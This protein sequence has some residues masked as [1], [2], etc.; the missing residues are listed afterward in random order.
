MMHNKSFF[1]RHIYSR[2]LKTILEPPSVGDKKNFQTWLFKTQCT[3]NIL[4]TFYYHKR[5]MLMILYTEFITY[6]LSQTC[7]GTE[8]DSVFC[9]LGKTEKKPQTTCYFNVASQ[10]PFWYN[11]KIC[12]IDIKRKA[13]QMLDI[14][15]AF[16]LVFTR[17]LFKQKNEG[18]LGL[19][20]MKTLCCSFYLNY[21]SIFL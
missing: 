11:L 21:L 19:I 9:S 1:V 14:C 20:L 12:G 5:C 3:Q 6:F 2:I 18:T 15:L 16:Y 8:S 10:Q 13:F 7:F 17:H 4:I